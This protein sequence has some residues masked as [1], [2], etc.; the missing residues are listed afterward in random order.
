MV[1]RLACRKTLKQQYRKYRVAYNC[2]AFLEKKYIEPYH[3]HAFIDKPH[4][5]S[6]ADFKASFEDNWKYGKVFISSETQGK[7]LK[8]ICKFKDKELNQYR[9]SDS[10]II[11]SLVLHNKL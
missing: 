4:N 2:I 3:I 1:F 10:L 9:F 5:V 11:S 7:Y 6:E 8:Y